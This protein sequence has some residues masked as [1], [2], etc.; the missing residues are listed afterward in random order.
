M[1]DKEFQ[2]IFKDNHIK[3]GSTITE[4][5]DILGKPSEVNVDKVTGKF[6]WIYDSSNFNLLHYEFTKLDHFK[7]VIIVF[8]Q[9]EIVENFKYHIK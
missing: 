8:N 7:F 1:T 3:K 5:I 6:S 2:N 9:D 4:V